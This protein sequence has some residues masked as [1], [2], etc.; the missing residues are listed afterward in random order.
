[1]IDHGTGRTRYRLLETIR[2]FARNL[3]EDTDEADDIRLE[4]VE[5]AVKGFTTQAAAPA[6]ADPC[7]RIPRS[8]R[9]AVASDIPLS[10]SSKAAIE[11]YAACFRLQAAGSGSVSTR[12]AR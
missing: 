10:N 5:A 8:R 4:R 9:A 12:R 11:T 1:M 6:T 3:F 2:Q 7:T